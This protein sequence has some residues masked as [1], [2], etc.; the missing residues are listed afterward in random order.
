M[1]KFDAQSAKVEFDR[2]VEA[3]KITPLKLSK[4]EEETD[5]VLACIEEGNVSVND[6]GS[7]EC[8]LMY[9][10]EDDEGNVAK[11]IIK[12]KTRRIRVEDLERKMQGK[13]DLEKVRRMMAFLAEDTPAAMFAKL[14]SDDFKVCSDIAAFFLPR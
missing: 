13:T 10:I 5:S 9:P 11:D 3:M 12:F 1:G 4:L 2:F 8:K 14:D 7:I 6:N